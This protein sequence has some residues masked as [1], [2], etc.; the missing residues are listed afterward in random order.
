MKLT[1]KRRRVCSRDG[2][3]SFVLKIRCIASREETAKIVSAV[4]TACPRDSYIEKV[5]ATP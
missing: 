1:M 4:L 3:D 5:K 2:E